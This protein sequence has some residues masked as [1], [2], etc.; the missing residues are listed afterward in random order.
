MNTETLERKYSLTIIVDHLPISTRIVTSI[1][2]YLQWNI[3]LIAKNKKLKNLEK[4][5]LQKFVISMNLFTN[6]CF[7]LI[8]SLGFGRM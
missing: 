2:L 7:I 5:E 3:S 8:G 4:I 1:V 6:I